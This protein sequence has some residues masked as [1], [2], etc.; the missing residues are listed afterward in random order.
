M[1][2]YFLYEDELLAAIHQVALSAC[3]RA[4][5]SIAPCR[6][7]HL[8]ALVDELAGRLEHSYAAAMERRQKLRAALAPLGSARCQ[9]PRV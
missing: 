5:S 3:R 4:R 8:E 7:Q 9:K 1:V 6:S 2:G